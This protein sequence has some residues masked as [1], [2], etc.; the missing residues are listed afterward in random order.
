MKGK[1]QGSAAQSAVSVGVPGAGG[2]PAAQVAGGSAG[3]LVAP[4]GAAVVVTAP[5]S[6]TAS[7]SADTPVAPEA[8][9]ARQPLLKVRRSTWQAPKFFQ[10]KFSRTDILFLVLLGIFALAFRMETPMV[11]HTGVDSRDYWEAAHSIVS[12][13]EFP[14]L[15]HRTSRWTLI[16]PIAVG[17]L[18]LGTDN[19]NAVYFVPWLFAVLQ[20][21]AFYLLGRKI[22]GRGVGFYSALAIT[23]FPYAIRTGSQLMPETVS[24]V[25]LAF[26]FLL[27]LKFFETGSP[28]R[29]ATGGTSAAAGSAA[30]LGWLAG[31]AVLLFAAYQAKITNLYFLP[32][33][34]LAIHLL[35]RSTGTGGD[36]A[37]WLA[38]LNP[39]V[40]FGGVLFGLYI[41]ET[42]AY[43]IF[44]KYPLGQL[45]IILTTHLGESVAYDY[46]GFF[47]L[48]LRY[49]E[50]HLQLYWQLPFLL[51]AVLA[52]VVLVRVAKARKAG[53]ATPAGAVPGAAPGKG[54]DSVADAKARKAGAAT[55]A[56]TMTDAV[57][58]PVLVLLAAGL[59]FF[60]CITFGFRNLEP[61]KLIERF[62]NRY[63]MAVLVVVFPLLVWGLAYLFRSYVQLPGPLGRPVFRR[64]ASLVLVVLLAVA[65]L[66]A[67]T[68]PGIRR[69]VAEFSWDP[70]RP[71]T[72]PLSLNLEYSAQLADALRSGRPIVA[73]AGNAGKN[74]LQTARYFYMGAPDTAPRIQ[75]VV[76]DLTPAGAVAIVE[77][78]DPAEAP[79][80]SSA[81]PAGKVVQYIGPLPTD[82][83]QQ[84]LVVDRAPFR[85]YQ[86]RLADF[87]ANYRDSGSDSE[88][89]ETGEE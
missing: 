60:I 84:V 62:L 49:A 67:F 36:K 9:R 78:A 74:A 15:T 33:L 53:A 42:A 23:V 12:G 30:G 46:S 76:L 28:P 3:A 56:G 85:T 31:S 88:L 7:V 22:G 26:S 37:Q 24:L 38:R 83:Q 68:N 64:A 43:A 72:H 55:P 65:P 51:F 58:V 35:R 1:Q 39:A 10:S 41:V 2:A 52:A 8:P 34:L 86:T 25:Y 17:Q 82:G 6:V 80:F 16:L 54:T 57:P 79:A 45:Q 81:L 73:V 4:V 14:E 32:G 77:A 70:A 69:A 11:H 59:S 47:A 87:L 44:T 21:V 89:S 66:V 63:F 19:A 18:L 71:Q 27:L 40:F 61:L 20:A 48:F 5:V 50:P 13:S 29:G 75:S